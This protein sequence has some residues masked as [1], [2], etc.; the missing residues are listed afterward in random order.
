VSG[1]SKLGD[2][3]RQFESL[4][5]RQ[6]VREMQPEEGDSVYGM[7]QDRLA[8][9]IAAGGGLGFAKM[10]E[11]ALDRQSQARGGPSSPDSSQLK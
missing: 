2:V 11:R 1:V 10:L 7:A 6:L 4:V 5:A 3:I 8:D 9:A